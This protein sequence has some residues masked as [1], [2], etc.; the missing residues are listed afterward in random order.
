MDGFTV[1]MLTIAAVI[2]LPSIEMLPSSVRKPHATVLGAFGRSSQID[3][4]QCKT[5]ARNETEGKEQAREP[6]VHSDYWMVQFVAWTDTEAFPAVQGGVGRARCFSPGMIPP[7]S[8]WKNSR[9]TRAWRFC[10]PLMAVRSPQQRASR[11]P[12]MASTRYTNAWPGSMH[13]SADFV[14]P[15]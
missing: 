3:C 4:R 9:S 15:G 10:V 2:P 12:K 11:P 8:R 13:L 1:E 14:P 7:Q 6:E 5:S